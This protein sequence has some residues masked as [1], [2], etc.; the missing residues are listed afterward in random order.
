VNGLQACIRKGLIDYL[1]ESSP[2]LFAIQETKVNACQRSAVFEGYYS[3]WSFA[4]RLGYS[5]TACFFKEMPLGTRLGLGNSKLDCEG[6]LITLDYSCF[7]LMCV[8]VPNSQG[9]LERWY[10]RLDWDKTFYEYVESLQSRKPVI[11]VGDFNVARDYIDVY[12]ENLRNEKNPP[13]FMT[14]ERDA[15]NSLLDLGLVDVFREL[16]PDLQG[17]Y[18]WWSNRLNKRKESRGWRLDYALASERLMPRV[19]S[20]VIRSDVYGSDHAPVEVVITI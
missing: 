11:I 19:Q 10:Y 18:T 3:E 14:E 6:R 7:Y 5:G 15:F 12:P 16:N 4:K 1:Q 17:A 8:Y 2:D 9:G 13:G 20:C